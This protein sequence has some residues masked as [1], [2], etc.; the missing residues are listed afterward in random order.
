LQYNV[1]QEVGDF[2]ILRKNKMPA[3]QL[4]VV[5]DDHGDG[6][7]EVIRG[8]DLLPSTARQRLIAQALGL[9]LPRYFHVPLLLDHNGGAWPTGCGIGIECI[10]R[11]RS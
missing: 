3:Y 8:S 5:I 7:T 1:A 4:A 10:T 11:K 9:P 6:V 2:L